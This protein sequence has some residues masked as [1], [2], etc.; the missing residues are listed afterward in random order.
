M[1]K[2]FYSNISQ[3]YRERGGGDLSEQEVDAYLKARMPATFAAVSAVLKE[4]SAR[5]RVSIHTVLDLGAGPGTGLLAARGI[6]PEIEK[7][8][9]VERNE[10]MIKKGKELI[11]GGWTRADLQSYSPSAHDLVLFAYSFGELDG[12]IDLLK[13]AWEAAQVLVIVEPGTP[14]GFANILKARDHLI[15]WGGKMI[16]PCPAMKPCPMPNNQ[17]CHFSVRLER[18][19]EHRQLKGGQLGWEDEKFSYVAFGKESV[20]MAKARIIGHPQKQSGNLILPLCTEEGLLEKRI[21]KKEQALY[22]QSRKAKWGDP[23]IF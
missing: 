21:S 5:I 16:A 13:K 8:T 14:R 7:W 11:E 4:V 20:E 18:T 2:N 12:Q 15:E 22:K 3:K 10:G 9:L 19:K 1:S 6:F 17:W 23:I